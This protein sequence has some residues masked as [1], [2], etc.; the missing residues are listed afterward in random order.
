M[1]L[2]I[3]DQCP[4]PPDAG[5]PTPASRNLTPTLTPDPCPYALTAGRL[6]AQGRAV[7]SCP[8]N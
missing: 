5:P 6:L 2:L 4:L 8:A 1:D 3:P 7:S